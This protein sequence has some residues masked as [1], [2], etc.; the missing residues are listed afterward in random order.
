MWSPHESGV[1]VE[2]AVDDLRWALA[3]TVDGDLATRARLQL[4]L[5]V[6]LY[7]DPDHRAE[8]EALVTSGLALARRSGDPELLWW[9]ARAAWSALWM[10]A[11]TERRPDLT[12]EGLAAARDVGDR[13]AEAVLL[14]GHAVDALELARREEWESFSAEAERIARRERLPYVLLTLSWLRMSLAAIGGRE[15]DAARHHAE[16]TQ[17]APLVAVPHQDVQAAAALTMSALW[18]PERLRSML[19]Q[20]REA[21]AE[22]GAGAVLLHSILARTGTVDELAEARAAMPVEHVPVD[23]WATL[24][25]WATEAESAAVLGDRE[26]ARRAL[27]VLAPYAGRLVVTGAVFTM[28][29]VDGYLA[30]VHA[31]LGDLDAAPRHADAAHDLAVEWEMDAYIRWLAGHRERLRIQPLPSRSQERGAVLDP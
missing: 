11:H 6:E 23:Y 28:G 15:E 27:E 25:D 19:A 12:A 20:M 21:Q 14:V 3:R 18:A 17:T 13:A 30:L 16:L 4:S 26:L 5:A 9:A 1:V 2:D 29:P 10:P 31:T 24:G 22:H 7:Y 8:S